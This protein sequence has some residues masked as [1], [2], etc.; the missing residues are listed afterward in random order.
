MS[1]FSVPVSN[2]MS[3]PV[4]SVEAI[5]LLADVDK[6]MVAK[7]VS[8][9]AVISATGKTAGVITRTDLLKVGRRQ[10]GAM[11]GAALL[12]F[13]NKPVSEVMTKDIVTLTGDESLEDASRV[14]LENGYHRIYVTDNEGATIG[15]LSTRDI[16]LAIAQQRLNKP[17]SDYMSSPA[18]TVR[19]SEPISLASER[20][21]KARVSGLIVMDKD[22][23]V[24][25]FTQTV[26]LGAKDL[27]KDTHV[28]EVMDHSMLLLDPHT[29]V[30][31]AAAQA[32]A[33][34]VRR[35]VVWDGNK[36]QGILT[37][38]DFAAVAASVVAKE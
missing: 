16:M 17:I 10:A 30:F 26:A 37:G 2:F 5:M 36:V 11:Q 1:H 8:S 19:A 21:A 14:M 28:D 20:L 31:R 24:G 33:M 7:K 25:L 38:L 23:P 15:V 13:P 27:P 4:H 29:P 12:T 32:A 3:S 6:E 22:W 18:F 34:D 9:L 35:V